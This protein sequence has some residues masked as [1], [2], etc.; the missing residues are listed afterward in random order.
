MTFEF[1]FK[2]ISWIL[3][4]GVNTQLVL[5]S[6]VYAVQLAGI[7]VSRYFSWLSLFIRV[8]GIG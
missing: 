4:A 8:H 6:I 7:G 1:G 5:I 2:R 3:M